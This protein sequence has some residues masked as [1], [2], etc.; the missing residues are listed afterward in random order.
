MKNTTADQSAHQDVKP[1]LQ[2]EMMKNRAVLIYKK[3]AKKEKETQEQQ[4]RRAEVVRYLNFL[5]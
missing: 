1:S 2:S 3:G 4:T 5:N